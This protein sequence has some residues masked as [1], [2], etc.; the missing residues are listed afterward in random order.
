MKYLIIFLA[1]IFIGCKTYSQ[2]DSTGNLKFYVDTSTNTFKIFN[3][4]IS[5]VDTIIVDTYFGSDTIVLP[6][7]IIRTAAAFT[8]LIWQSEGVNLS[9]ENYK[10][11]SICASDSMNCVNL[12]QAY[13][14]AKTSTPGGDALSATNRYTLILPAG[15]Y[16]CADTFRVDA[17]YVDIVSLTGNRDVILSGSTIKVTA[18][19]V[20]IKGID[21]GTNPFIL[22]TN[23]N[24]LKLE[25]C[26]GLGSGSFG[27]TEKT[28]S[29]TFIECIGGTASFFGT[30]ITLSG[31]FINCE[32]GALSFAGTSST[33]SGNFTNCVALNASFAGSSATISGNFINCVGGANSFGG[34][35]STT[36]G[37]LTGCIG[38]S[39][40]FNTTITGKLQYCRINGTG[41]F[42]T[43]SGG[44]INVHYINGDGTSDN[45]VN[46]DEQDLGYTASTGAITITN[47]TG[48]TIPLATATVR[49]LLPTPPNDTTKYLRGDATWQTISAGSADEQDLSYTAATGA[50]DI[51]GGT[52]TTIPVATA[53]TRGL[54]PDPPD[55]ANFY[56][57]G[58]GTFDEFREKII[59]LDS[60]YNTNSTS[61]VNIG[62]LTVNLAVGNYYL[63]FNHVHNANVS[64]ESC[65]FGI[66]TGT[67]TLGDKTFSRQTA[68]GTLSFAVAYNSDTNSFPA[69]SNGATILVS[70]E[71]KAYIQVTGA[72]TMIPTFRTET[73]GA[74]SCTIKEGLSFLKITKL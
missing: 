74:N 60:S 36:S 13:T 70:G 51:S 46:T 19:D 6:D 29:G 9:C 42:P 7:T 12:N 14:E 18:N 34:T 15:Y 63:E 16:Q 44:G 27:G 72:G 49:G 47:G 54:V 52:G 62:K 3:K 11:L 66:A 5:I 61:Y 58:D 67:A 10:I 43:P 48:I 39:S 4:Q 21:V 1:I 24:N 59:V 38:G 45:A 2:A 31:N 55:D 33:L 57:A 73:G 26:K 65:S 25:K 68:N 64:S 37:Q 28:I 8:D 71:V 23:L 40:S 22:E 20:F 32:G 30:S 41:S 69:P 56:F 50:L 35:S 53:T 17:Q